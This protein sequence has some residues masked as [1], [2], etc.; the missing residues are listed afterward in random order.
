MFIFFNYDHSL[1]NLSWAFVNHSYLTL[2]YL[3]TFVGKVICLINYE[4]ICYFFK[5]GYFFVTLPDFTGQ[6]PETMCEGHQKRANSYWTR[7]M[8]VTELCSCSS[9]EQQRQPSRKHN[10]CLWLAEFKSIITLQRTFACVYGND[11]NMVRAIYGNGSVGLKSTLDPQK[12]VM[13]I[14][15]FGK[16]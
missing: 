12:Q 9:R 7:Y 5:E 4:W 10:V 6:W 2:G 13:K 16:L 3:I 15:S 1:H 8:V 11:H 14:L